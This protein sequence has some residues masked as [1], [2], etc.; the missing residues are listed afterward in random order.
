MNFTI[1]SLNQ[2]FILE[3]GISYD[4]LRHH[5]PNESKI[6]SIYQVSTTGKEFLI[7]RSELCT[8][9]DSCFDHFTEESL[10]AITKILSKD[11]D[12][13]LRSQVRERSA[14][15][16]RQSNSKKEEQERRI[17]FEKERLERE[18]REQFERVERERRERE[19][20]E[21]R[22]REEHERREMEER[23]RFEREEREHRE[24]EER[25][26]FEREE[27]E[28][29]EREERE[30]IKREQREIEEQRIKENMFREKNKESSR[31]HSMNRIKF[32]ENNRDLNYNEPVQKIELLRMISQL[33][34]QIE[35]M[36]RYIHKM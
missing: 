34:Q 11:P 3:T 30:R 26:R 15:K 9:L 1:K 10:V 7:P 8:I 14:S 18:H 5:F 33:K 32:V 23:E 19:E 25:E 24:M 22:E 29:F 36:E 28:R 2:D 12:V 31:E 21:R 27:R 4:E 6:L 16:K 35:V 20:H 17:R 13:E